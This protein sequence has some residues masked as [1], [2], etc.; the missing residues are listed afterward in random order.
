MNLDRLFWIWFIIVGFISVYMLLLDTSIYGFILPL[1]L[2]GLGLDRLA[3]ESRK[4]DS[5]KADKKL[6]DKLKSK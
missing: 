5:V 4:E 3:N 6:L 1:V 2:I